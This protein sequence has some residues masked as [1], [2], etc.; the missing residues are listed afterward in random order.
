MRNL[1]AQTDLFSEESWRETFQVIPKLPFSFSYQF[2]DSDGR[3]S[4]LQILDW[5][6]GALY[7]NCYRRYGQNDKAAIEKVRAKYLTEF[8]QPTCTFSWEPLSNITKLH[9]TRG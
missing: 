4:T 8:L 5:E 2:A 6:I 7:W 1:H 9:P 3:E